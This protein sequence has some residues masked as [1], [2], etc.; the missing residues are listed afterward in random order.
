M[1]VDINITEDLIDKLLP[2]FTLQPLVE[3]AI[4][5]GIGNFLEGG[6]VRIYSQKNS[7]GY[8]ITVEDNAGSF[9]PPKPDHQG[10]GMDIVNKRLTNYFGNMA[11]LQTHCQKGKFTRMSFLIPNAKIGN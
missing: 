2:S 7:L 3:N 8:R 11:E 5:H 4:K 1:E 9:L 10:L 6:K